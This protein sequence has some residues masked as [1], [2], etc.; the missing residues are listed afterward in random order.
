MKF[1]RPR[2]LVSRFMFATLPIYPPLPLDELQASYARNEYRSNTR[3]P[4]RLP[5]AC[6]LC[7]SSITS[8]TCVRQYCTVSATRSEKTL[9]D[10]SRGCELPVVPVRAP[11]EVS[12]SEAIFVFKAIAIG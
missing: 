1:M 11:A 3:T 5:K 10:T 2:I 4:I 8:S 12:V 7:S 6:N 9:S